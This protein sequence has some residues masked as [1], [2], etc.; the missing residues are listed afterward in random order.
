MSRDAG[1][2][3]F[4]GEGEFDFAL[5]IGELRLL[6]ESRSRSLAAHG[7]SPGEACLERMLGRLIGGGWLIE[8]V[9]EILR[10]GLVGGGMR[11]ERAYDL[12][13]RHVA[14]PDLMACASTAY[15]VLA[16]ALV[17]SPEDQPGGGDPSGEPPGEA[18]DTAPTSSP[19]DDGAGAST[20]DRAPS[21]DTGPAT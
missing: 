7:F 14:P 16:A 10:L 8:E 13:E 2:R 21:S 17:G 11:K 3:L 19:T 1:I 4:L 18:T 6:E 12:V 9:R 20:T 5:R 15:A